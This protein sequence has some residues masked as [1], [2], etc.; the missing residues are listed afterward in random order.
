[1]VYHH[2]VDVVIVDEEIFVGDS[3]VLGSIA[4]KSIRASRPQVCPLDMQMRD[5]LSMAR[6]QLEKV[7]STFRHT[8]YLRALSQENRCFILRSTYDNSRDLICE[9]FRSLVSLRKFTLLILPVFKSVLVTDD[10]CT[11]KK[12]D[13]RGERRLQSISQHLHFCSFRLGSSGK[14]ARQ[15][16]LMARFVVKYVLIS[17]SYPVKSTMIFSKNINLNQFK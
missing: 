13:H 1:M 17:K 8:F 5:L 14:I 2:I 6:I 7:F 12:D 15:L 9:G 11:R 10:N 4:V 16:G 3:V